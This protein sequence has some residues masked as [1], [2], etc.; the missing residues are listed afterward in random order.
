MAP[1]DWPRNYHQIAQEILLGGEWLIVRGLG[2]L[3]QSK[4]VIPCQS[5]KE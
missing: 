2:D 5:E 4:Y 3:E 1:L